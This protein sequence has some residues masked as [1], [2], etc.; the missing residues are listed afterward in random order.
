MAG[1]R[2]AARELARQILRDLTVAGRDGKLTRR[3]LARAD[4]Y[5]SLA[6]EARAEVDTVLKAFASQR[7]IVLSEDDIEISHD[8]LLRAWPRLKAWLEDDQASWLLYAALADDAHDWQE[9][10]KNSSFLYRGAHLGCR[11]AGRRPMGANPARYP[12]LTPAESEFLR[13]SQRAATRRT[14]LIWA[15][16]AGLVLLVAIASSQWGLARSAQSTAEQ[17]RSQAVFNQTAA[18]A[19]HSPRP[20][21]RSR[22]SSTL[23]HTG[24]SRRRPHVAADQHGEHP[25]ARHLGSSAS[26]SPVFAVASRPGAGPGGHSMAI[27]HLHRH[28]PAVWTSRPL[29]RHDCSAE[30]VGGIS[31][32]A[33]AALAFR[34]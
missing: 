7:L 23:P 1:C 30:P 12:A 29:A 24:C 21:G 34:P 3:P 31:T 15:G 20:T 26:P 32:N 8:V 18:E 2:R 10:G 11:A 16:V 14:R 13:V 6:S 19:Q 4:L 5:A 33:I 27:R 17:Q 22:L 28:R 25:Y 9:H